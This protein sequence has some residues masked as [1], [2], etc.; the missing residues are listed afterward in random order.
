MKKTKITVILTAALLLLYF[1]SLPAVSMTTDTKGKQYDDA[2]FELEEKLALWENRGEDSDIRDLERL[3]NV[4]ANLSGSSAQHSKGFRLYLEVLI[5]IAYDSYDLAESSL[6]QLERSTDFRRYLESIHSQYVHI[7]TFEQLQNYSEGR[8]NEY[9]GEETSDNIEEITYYRKAISSY[10]KCDGWLDSALR[11]WSLEKVVK[12]YLKTLSNRIQPDMVVKFGQ[13]AQRQNYPE[14]IEWIVLSV[15]KANGTAKLLSKYLLDC[16]QYHTSDSGV[17][18]GDCYIRYWL[19]HDFFRSA[20]SYEEQQAILMTYASGSQ[21]SVTMLDKREIE[22]SN[23]AQ[24]CKATSY[25]I[26][27]GVDVGNDNGLSCWWVRADYVPGTTTVWVGIHGGIY[28]KNRAT[29]RNN[30]VRPVI[31]VNLNSFINFVEF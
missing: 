7:G 4:F 1:S 29:I 30:G 3:K 16:V 14:K 31:T 17:S 19:N 25:A 22:S 9:L 28:N 10:L 11:N 21:D 15:D 23:F 24:G 20:F 13:Y 12:S 5:N 8:K 2:V 27:R 6:Y 26:S 18:W